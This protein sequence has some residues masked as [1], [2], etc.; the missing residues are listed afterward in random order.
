MICQNSKSQMRRWISS[1]SPNRFSGGQSSFLLLPWPAPSWIKD[2]C[3]SSLAQCQNAYATISFFFSF[4]L[5]LE[6]PGRIISITQNH[7][8]WTLELWWQLIRKEEIPKI[9]RIKNIPE[10]A[11]KILESSDIILISK[12]PGPPLKLTT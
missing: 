4:F 7:Y 3:Y 12:K 9:S 1:K 2:N 5:P 11:P 8:T 6:L 10:N